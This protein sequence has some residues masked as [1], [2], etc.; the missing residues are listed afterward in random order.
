[1]KI[2]SSAKAIAHGFS[3][4]VARICIVSFPDSCKFGGGIGG[5]PDGEVRITIDAIIAAIIPAILILL[6]TTKKLFKS[7]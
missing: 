6:S 3:R 5:G 2:L 4:L 1:M 7:Y